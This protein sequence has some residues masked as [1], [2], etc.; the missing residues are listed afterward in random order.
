LIGHENSFFHGKTTF[1]LAH[2]DFRRIIDLGAV[3][4]AYGGPVAL[5]FTAQALSRCLARRLT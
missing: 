3:I 2:I 4:H 5:G 1:R